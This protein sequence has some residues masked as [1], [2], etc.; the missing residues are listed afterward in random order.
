MAERVLVIGSGG[1]EHALAWK[2]AQSPHVKHVFVA[3]GNAGTAD[4][5]KISNSAVLVSNHTIVTQFCKDHNIGLVLV[6]PE[7]LLA[8]GIADDLRAAGVRCLGPCARAAQLASHSSSSRA[9]LQR[10][11]LP[12][13]RWRAFSSPQ[14]ACR[15]I[16]S[17]DFPA[18][19]VRARGPAARREVTIA[20]SKE[21]ACRAVQEIL[22][23]RMFGEMVVIEELLQGE[24]LSCSCFTDGVTVASLPPA[25]P[26][27]RLQDGERGPSTA[28]MGAYCPVPQVPEALL[29]QIRGSILQHIVESLR[30]EGAAYVGVLQT[31]L[32][33]TEEGVKILNFKCQFGDPQCQVILP[34]L[35]N[36]FYEV[37]QATIDG[38]LSSCMPAW[39]E[40]RT[41]VCVVMASPGYP[42]DSEKGMEVTGLLQAQQLGLQVFHGGTALKDGRVVTS[43]GRVLS[44]TAVRQDLL[45]A[46]G[47]ANRGVATIHFQGATFRR[48][49]GHRG[50]RLLQQPLALVYKDR[51]VAAGT[52]GVWS[53]LP[54]TSA[55]RGTR[56]GGRSEGGGFAAFF[57]LK[58]SGYEDP[59]LVSQ[60]KGLGPKLQVAQVCKRHDTIGQDLVALCVNDLLAQGAEPLFFLTHL[61]CGKLDTEVL[62]TIKEGIA[63]ACRSAGC[64]FLGAEVTE[65][66]APCPPGRCDLAGF[67]VGAVERGQRP[68]GLRRAEEGDA[69]LGL[70]CAS[71]PGCAFGVV[72]RILLTSS[73][74]CSSPAPGTCGGTTLGDVLLTPGKMFS[75]ALLPVLRS[76]HVKGFAPTAEG[77]LG[78][79]SRLLPE[80]LSAI[81]DA[82]S[83]KMPEIFGWLYKEGNL[84]AEE[85]AQTF[86]CGLGAVLVVQ[87]E[88][89]QHVLQDI[90]RQ[91]EAWLV[92]KVVAPC[93]T[94]SHV[95]VENLA[96]ALQLS[97]PQ[98]P[99][100][101]SAAESPGRRK[102]KVAV[103]VS[104]A[105]RALPAL[106]GSARE[107]GSSARLVLLISNRP[108][109]PE[110]RCAARAGIPTRV[111]DHK[112]Y[113]SR[114]EF[115][116]TID[117]VLEEFSVELICLSGFSRVLS[118]PFLRKWKGKILNA[119]PSLFPLTKDGNAHQEPLESGFKVAGC[120]V[121]FVL[122]CGPCRAPCARRRS[123]AP[124]PPSAGSRW[125]AA[126]GLRWRSG[127][128]R[129]SS[130]PSPRPCSSWPAAPCG[131]EP[132]EEPAG[133]GRA[134]GRA[135]RR[136]R[137]R[138]RR[139]WRGCGQGPEG[140]C[141]RPLLFPS[142]HVLL[143]DVSVSQASIPSLFPELAAFVKPPWKIQAG[144]EF[145]RSVFKPAK[146]KMCYMDWARAVKLICCFRGEF[147][148]PRAPFQGQ[149]SGSLP[150]EPQRGS[151][152]A[153]VGQ[154][155]RGAAGEIQR[156]HGAAPGLEPL[157]SQAGRAGGAPLERR[158]SRESSEPLPGPEG[159]P[160]E[161]QRD[162]CQGLQGQEPGNGSQCQRAGLDGLLG[163]RNCSLAGWAGPGTGCPEQLWLPLHPWQCPRPGWTLGLEQ[164]GAVGGVPA[165]AGVALGGL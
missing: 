24:E 54:Q 101:D 116:S 141:S 36:D 35:K 26:H 113:G 42:G 90:Q 107:R 5:G 164:P 150:E 153:G 20:A 46:V 8:A 78:G 2:L 60:T 69:L 79:I 108:G 75:P 114:S 97:C 94:G 13:A 29:E 48:D 14:E 95:E 137:E 102:V 57:D 138:P 51:P 161:L 55:L 65:A 123:R 130:G 151:A 11:G 21:E 144:L 160:G 86:P 103:L 72:R 39:S 16:T 98:Q 58:A 104:G 9:F 76:G 12:T 89:A 77:L 99:P 80:H 134:K 23:D 91:Q 19:V 59:I 148:L 149:S 146:E 10:H 73:L 84:S 133:G 64:A 71:I 53:H 128:G 44:V 50:L 124:R 92:G 85:M 145:L 126:R 34:L 74:H 62:E 93:H 100:G 131:W 152:A 122:R 129:P 67:A 88:L 96:E 3:P 43:G 4:N 115:D 82:L 119:S 66:A 165:M 147:T 87:K 81:L 110:L 120:T 63:E 156:G 6:G 52:S 70:G 117:R 45:E 18:R 31:G 49:I 41:A 37:I 38:K 135:R 109:V 163:I 106:I 1:R 33:L 68:P 136:S 7:A 61:T 112:L 56:A 132:M 142:P 127:C 162:N 25:Q 17:T 40:N 32:M 143:L 22:Q 47:E 28:G 157:W 154:Q 118:G 158:S 139:S 30:Q 155:S 140:L 159:A 15:F 125:R 83:W 111:I 105:G 121:H 27:K